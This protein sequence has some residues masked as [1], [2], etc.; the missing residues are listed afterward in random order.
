MESDFINDPNVG[1]FV[2][3]IKNGTYNIRN[4]YGSLELPNFYSDHIAELLEHVTDMSLIS[5]YPLPPFS[6]VKVSDLKLGICL[7]WTIEGIRIGTKYPSMTPRLLVST[8]AGDRECT[9]A[10]ALEV[11]Q[12]YKL[13]WK[14][15]YPFNR[16]HDKYTVNPLEETNYYW[17]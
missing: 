15:E 7:L 10:E 5:D 11:A 16:L 17:Y 1:V 4:E 12:L 3:Q 8:E 9:E 6:S 14:G 13:W 2:K